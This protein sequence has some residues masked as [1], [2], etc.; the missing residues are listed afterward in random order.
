MESR[1][2]VLKSL[3]ENNLFTK[4]VSSGIV[5]I[6]VATRLSIYEEYLKHFNGFNK[7]QAIKVVAASMKVSESNLYSIIRY[8]E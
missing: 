3:K 2:E 5:T 8:M 6:D 7:S 4:L 1:H